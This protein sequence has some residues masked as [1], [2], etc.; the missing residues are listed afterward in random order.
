MIR[1]SRDEFHALA[2]SEFAALP[3]EL[4]LLLV[5]VEIATLARPGREAGKWE[6]S[7]T[8]LG[9]YSGLTRAEMGADA[10]PHLPA[11]VILYQRNL[12]ARCGDEKDLARAVRDTLRHE[13]GHHLGMSDA[14]LIRLGY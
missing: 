3:Q 6:G 8:L 10:G 11:R 1:L 14:E 2:E 7:R 5:N 4:K 9:L 13:L 12:E